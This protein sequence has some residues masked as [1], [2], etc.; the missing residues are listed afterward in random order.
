MGD[1]ANQRQNNDKNKWF[2]WVVETGE[3]VADGTLL[4]TAKTLANSVRT[5]EVT[6]KPE[7]D[8]TVERSSTEDS[9]MI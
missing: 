6:A 8:G 4:T 9:G 7:D 2:G 1:W 5:G 3:Q